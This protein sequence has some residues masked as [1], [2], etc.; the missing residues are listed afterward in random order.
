MKKQNLIVFDDDI[1]LWF[2]L[3]SSLNHTLLFQ[4][5]SDQTLHTIL[6]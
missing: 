4:K 1:Y 5:I 6:S 3:F 2:N